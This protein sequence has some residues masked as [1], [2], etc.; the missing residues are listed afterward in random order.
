M[1]GDTHAGMAHASN[2][3]AISYNELSGLAVLADGMGGY[4]GADSASR[5]V[6]ETFSA[7]FRAGADIRNIAL[8]AN[9]KILERA[10]SETRLRKMGSTVVAAFAD[11]FGF[12][13]VWAGDSRA[14]LWRRECGL[15]LVTRDHCLASIGGKYEGSTADC[16]SFPNALTRVLGRKDV[17]PE[18][19]RGDWGGGDLLLLCSDGLYKDLGEIDMEQTLRDH[20]SAER[21]VSILIQKALANGGRD[22]I[23][24]I[25]LENKQKGLHPASKN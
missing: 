20:E 23:S 1:F 18:R 25:L 22:D 12:E 17:Q 4:P 13:I 16:E 7:L 21:S 15:S 8:N 6:V 11:D 3:D 2:Q 14:Y 9:G 5:I 19:L 24:A 10:S